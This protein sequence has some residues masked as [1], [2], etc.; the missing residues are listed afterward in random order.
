MTVKEFYEYILYN[1]ASN[2]EL[3]KEIN[4]SPID[5][6]NISIDYTNETVML[7]ND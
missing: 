7:D 3:K 6:I 4:S 2:F 5:L 1:G